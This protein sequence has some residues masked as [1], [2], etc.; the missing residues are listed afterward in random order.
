MKNMEGGLTPARFTELSICRPP[1]GDNHENPVLFIPHHCPINH[2]AMPPS[3]L[4]EQPFAHAALSL[5]DLVA[6]HHNS[7]LTNPGVPRR[8]CGR[9]QLIDRRSSIIS[10][11]SI[12]SASL[13]MLYH[14]GIHSDR[15]CTERVSTARRIPD[16]HS[17]VSRGGGKLSKTAR[18]KSS[19]AWG[20]RVARAFRVL[21]R[22][23]FIGD[24]PLRRSLASHFS[25]Q[26]FRGKMR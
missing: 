14:L 11:L 15:F 21:P 2:G 23:L 7:S 8:I 5:F 1:S 25:L 13:A 24:T 3:S 6:S 4:H 17:G 18:L 26:I 19:T 12:F 9:H 10:E 22:S 20:P 16:H